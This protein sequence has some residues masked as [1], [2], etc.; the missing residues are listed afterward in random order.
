MNNRT[1]AA[2]LTAV[3][4]GAAWMMRKRQGK[5]KEVQMTSS[6]VDSIEQKTDEITFLLSEKNR[7]YRVY[8]DNQLIYSGAHSRITDQSLTPATSYLYTIER[9]DTSGCMLDIIQVQTSTLPEERNERNVLQDLVITAAAGNSLIMLEWEPIEGVEEYIVYRNGKKMAR[10]TDCFLIDPSIRHDKTYTYLIKA[11]RPLMLSE[12]SNSEER[13]AAAGVFGFFKKGA[14]EK[15]AAMEEFRIVKQ[16]PPIEKLLR[17]EEKKTKENGWMLRYTTFLTNKWL[18][19]PNFLSKYRYFAG[20]NRGFDPEAA[21]YRTRADVTIRFAED[22]LDV[23]LS[24]D[25]GTTKA[26]GW[27]K[28]FKEEGRASSDGIQMEETDRSDEKVSFRLSHAVGNPLMVTAPPVDYEVCAS[29]YK[30]GHYDMTGTHDQS[31][32]HEVYVRRE[33]S[34][35]WIPIHQARSKGLEWMA[36]PMADQFWRVSNF[37]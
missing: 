4:A 8:R 22:G 20:D 25:I 26:Y 15:E 18:K 10:I 19:N 21:S 24:S 16:F 33:G 31:P 34:D 6:I 27:S 36:A 30:R 12:R 37:K 9:T 13:F 7:N 17:P 2:A 1:I 11:R 3:G 32:H 35:N 23:N 28:K 14:S 29:F 5:R